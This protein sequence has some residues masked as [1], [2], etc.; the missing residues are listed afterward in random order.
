MPVLVSFRQYGICGFSNLIF[1]F[2]FVFR[3]VWCIWLV[4]WYRK[5]FHPSFLRYVSKYNF[6]TTCCYLIFINRIT[7]GYAGFLTSFLYSQLQVRHQAIK[8]CSIYRIYRLRSVK[9]SFSMSVGFSVVS[10]FSL[11]SPMTMML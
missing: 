5:V 3:N 9:L 10:S 7:L 8:H 2:N 6:P 11:M 1:I 4:Y